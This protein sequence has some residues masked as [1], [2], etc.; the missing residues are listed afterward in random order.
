[1]RVRRLQQRTCRLL[2]VSLY[3]WCVCMLVQ[4]L[5]AGSYVQ[6][7]AWRDASADRAWPRHV[8]VLTAHPDDEC[9]F[10]GPTIQ[11][12]LKL[13]VTISALCL[14][15]GNAEGLGAIREQEL[16]ASYGV[17]GVPRERVTCIDDHA[18]QDGMQ[19]E[20][21][22]RHIQ[23]VIETHLRITLPGQLLSNNHHNMTRTDVEA[24]LTFDEG[25]VSLH[26]N[27]RATYEGARMYVE[28]MRARKQGD[29][30]PPALWSLYS[31]TWRTKFLGPFSGVAQRW[32]R[33]DYV[34]LAPLRM[35]VT[36]LA[37]MRRHRTQLVWF[38]YLYVIFS[39][40]MQANRIYSTTM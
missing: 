1:M 36:S 17:L 14:S 38:R 26:P 23:D 3:A 39:S 11:S 40:Y 31:L 8:L 5:L 4:W 6:G 12:L 20:W 32:S 29:H 18:L 2:R 16:T 7:S 9:M 24:I 15:R 21:N 22:P 27:H 25:G 28:D 35:Y 10:F 33:S 34:F 13:N 37:A 30:K 19:E